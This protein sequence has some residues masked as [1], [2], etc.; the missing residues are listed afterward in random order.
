MAAAEAAVSI[1]RNHFWVAAVATSLGLISMVMDPQEASIA[2]TASAPEDMILLQSNHRMTRHVGHT[3]IWSSRD[4]YLDKDYPKDDQP[5]NPPKFTTEAPPPPMV[6]PEPPPLKD[7]PAPT[8]APKIVP[9][10]PAQQGPPWVWSKRDPYLDHDYTHDD[11]P[12]GKPNL[13]QSMSKENS[14]QEPSKEANA[15][16]NKTAAAEKAETKSGEDI[17]STEV[18]KAKAP[19]PESNMTLSNGTN[20]TTAAPSTGCMT[21]EDPRLTSWFTETAPAGTPC[22]FGVDVR[23]EGKHCVLDN[24]EYGSDGWCYTKPDKSEW[25]SCNSN[26]PLQGP[27]AKLGNMVDSVAKSVKGISEKM[28]SID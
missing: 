14:F 20:I 25:G 5:G 7:T 22:V 17:N 6:Y 13:L 27:H 8:P 21:R 10:P 19:S 16:T 15:T 11:Q 12:T 2:V 1:L 4:P 9:P 28:S 18:E 23:D 24:E 3:P 26:C